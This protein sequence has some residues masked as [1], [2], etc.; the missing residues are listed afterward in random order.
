VNAYADGLRMLAGRELSEAQVRQ[1]LA[2]RNHSPDNIDEAVARLRAEAAIDDVRAARA[3]ARRE[4]SIKGRGRLRARL[5]IERAGISRDL[6]ARAIDAVF[7]DVDD[8]ALLEAA[9]N[10]RLRGRDRPANDAE[11]R[12]VY[13]ALVA[14]GFEPDAV[15]RLLKARGRREL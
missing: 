7:E 11:F 8:D 1:R 9:L 13:R 4:V 3:I 14:R 2:R 12:R 15:L 10:R 5:A 6:A